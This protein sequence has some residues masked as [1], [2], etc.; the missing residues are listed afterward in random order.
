MSENFCIT[1]PIYYVNGNPHIGHIYTTFI[2]DT[3][4]R[5]RRLRGD[6][7]LFTTGTDEHG[8]KVEK[9]ANLKNV[10]TQK[11]VDDIAE[12]FKVLFKDIGIEYD[13]FIRT[14]QNRHK[15]AVQHIWSELL[16]KD[17]IYLGHYEG[18]Y[19]LRD[20]AF[21][22]EKELVDGKAPSGADVEWVKEESYFFRLSAFQNKLLEFY[23]ANPNF[24]TPKTRYNEVT[25]FVESGLKDLSISRTS[26]KWGIPVPNDEKHVIY[27][28][29]DALVNY[30]T[31]LGY[32][33]ID[34]EKW[35]FWPATHVIGKDILRFHGVYWPAFLMAADL[36]LPKQIAS[37]GWWTNEKEKISK[38]VGN[39]VNYDELIETFGIDSLRYFLLRE[40]PFGQDG[41]FSKSSFTQRYKSDLLNSY[42]N[43]AQRVFMFINKFN[44][45]VS[46][47]PFSLTIEDKNML[48]LSACLPEF[49]SYIKDFSLN[50]YICAIFEHINQANKYMEIHKPWELKKTNHKR[51]QTVLYVLLDKIRQIAMFTQPILPVTSDKILSYLA[52]STS[53]RKFS[54][55]NDALK[56]GIILEK[57]EPLFSKLDE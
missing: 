18:W 50:R 10:S 13:D 4:A 36:P 9:A 45:S 35:G 53:K 38:S 14:T 47:P 23:K 48:S 43:L 15:I 21:Y 6:K 49:D 7:V 22:D 24:I 46:P 42:G 30:I 55:L 26:F 25:R 33:C 51:M 8:Q 17:Q 37:H 3:V 5:Y 44:N 39:T 12:S 31:I 1:T 27:V 41:D 11:F 19:A 32:P 56:C 34:G 52:V 40:I 54:C 29:L 2:C 57:P 28:W 16:K 20:E